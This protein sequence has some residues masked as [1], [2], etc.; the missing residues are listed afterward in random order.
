MQPGSP[1]KAPTSKLVSPEQQWEPTPEARHYQSL[2]GVLEPWE[3]M[4]VE[5]PGE[6]PLFVSVS[7]NMYMATLNTCTA[8][9]TAGSFS[10]SKVT[11]DKT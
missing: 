8:A 6:M 2:D 4:G 1:P 11:G 7:L 3:P 10:F 9:L 5:S